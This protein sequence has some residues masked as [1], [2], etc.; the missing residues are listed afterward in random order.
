MKA[1][2]SL[3]DRLYALTLTAVLG[4]FVAMALACGSYDEA[5]YVRGED[6]PGLDEPAMSTGLDKQDLEA[7]FDEN[8]DKLLKSPFYREASNG[9]QRHSVAVFPFRNETSEHVGP[10][11]SALLAKVETEL[12]NDR[13]V[14][15][16]DHERQDALI[17]EMKLQQ[18]DLY[19]RDRAVEVGNRLGVDYFI[20]GKVYDSAER[21][22]DVRRVQYFLFMQV[23]SVETG[24]IEWQEES[25]LTKGLV[26][27]ESL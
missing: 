11:L 7:L 10:Q 22:S 4:V 20:T 6:A 5:T 24:K 21:T 1:R 13:K 23:V 12:V 18:S 19:D 2:H 9:D 26:P 8:M 17:K 14:D 16:I 15:V 25:N 27:V 3:S